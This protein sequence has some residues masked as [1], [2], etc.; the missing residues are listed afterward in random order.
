ML[1]DMH[2]ERTMYNSSNLSPKPAIVQEMETKPKNR[3]KDCETRWVGRK[4][5]KTEWEIS[6]QP[7]SY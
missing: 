3:P 1:L 5:N 2:R 6:H 7:P 4:S